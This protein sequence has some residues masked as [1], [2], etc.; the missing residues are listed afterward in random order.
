MKLQQIAALLLI[1]G[2]VLFLGVRLSDAQ[3]P[4]I[5]LDWTAPGDD[6]DVG[7]CT[8][9]SMRWSA[10]RPDTV[11]SGAPSSAWWNAATVVPGMPTPLPAGSRQSVT[12]AGPFTAGTYYFVLT[13]C[14]EV[15]NCSYSNVSVKTVTL[16]DV[17]FPA[18]I[19]DLKAR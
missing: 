2:A 10:A 5:T 16:L 14:D 4:S 19:V 12:V 18:R 17:I 1:V 15:P 6:G 7:T 8:V 13:A 11:S 3:V 9:Y